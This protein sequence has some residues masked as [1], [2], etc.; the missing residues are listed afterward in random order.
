[1][2]ESKLNSSG[3]RQ[4]VG[5]KNL[6]I[7]EIVALET[8]NVRVTFADG[9]VFWQEVQTTG[10]KGRYRVKDYNKLYL[11]KECTIPAPVTRRDKLIDTRD[12]VESGEWLNG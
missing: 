8:E 3:R 1:M 5:F 2:T 4:L 7:D 12:I 6:K 10:N 11:D 9:S